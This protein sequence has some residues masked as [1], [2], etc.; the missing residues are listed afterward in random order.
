MC[1]FINMRHMFT[2]GRILFFGYFVL[3]TSTTMA[4][5]TEINFPREYVYLSNTVRNMVEDADPSDLIKITLPATQETIDTVFNLFSLYHDPQKGQDALRNEIKTYSLEK[6][7][8][9]ANLLQHLHALDDI[10]NIIIN[11]I[12]M[13]LNDKLT[14]SFDSLKTYIYE[15]NGNIIVPYYEPLRQLN[16]DLEATIKKTV[17]SAK[18]I[19]PWRVE[20]IQ[21]IIGQQNSSEKYGQEIGQFQAGTEK[22]ASFLDRNVT[23]PILEF[24]EKNQK[25]R[26]ED[27][28]SHNAAL[29]V[30]N[31]NDTSLARGI[32][33]FAAASFAMLQKLYHYITYKRQ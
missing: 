3:F 26:L 15:N 25:K 13:I 9:I 33:T 18:N 4:M 1:Y 27:I 14:Q 21:K 19:L 28:L 17:F 30:Q 32:A 10:M 31:K 20:D 23:V 29:A 11:K 12:F 5:N 6:L 24:I 8:N 16:S 2:V 7:V 22:L